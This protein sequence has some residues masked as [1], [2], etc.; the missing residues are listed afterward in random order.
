MQDLQGR[1]IPWLESEGGEIT[2]YRTV[3][4]GSMGMLFLSCIKT[5]R[6]LYIPLYQ[7]SGCRFSRFFS[8]IR[9]FS[10][11]DT[12][13]NMIQRWMKKQKG[14]IT[15]TT[16]MVS[17]R[18]FLSL[19]ISSCVPGRTEGVARAF[20]PAHRI[21]PLKL[22]QEFT[23]SAAGYQVLLP[24]LLT[25]AF[26]CVEMSVVWYSR[27]SY[28]A[29]INLFPCTTTL[30]NASAL[31]HIDTSFIYNRKYE[32]NEGYSEDNDS[33]L[34]YQL[35]YAMIRLSVVCVWRVRSS[36]AAETQCVNTCK[37]PQ[38]YGEC[39]AKSLFTRRSKS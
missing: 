15:C 23:L 24:G 34:W 36:S 38:C 9:A 17:S 10:P 11:L 27:G 16:D 6:L 33:S 5:Q 32:F 35:S 31:R 28:E 21:P 12:Q 30:P 13:V 39:I 1:Y 19:A 8:F 20:S 25:V 37:T 18:R 7:R 3:L 14:L 22:M 4:C 2:I 26:F 29:I